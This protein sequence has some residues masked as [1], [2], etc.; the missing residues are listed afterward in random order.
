MTLVYAAWIG[1]LHAYLNSAHE[2]AVTSLARD[3]GFIQVSTSYQTS[4]LAKLVGRGDTTVVDAYLS[5]IL[6]QYVDHI[7][8]A[9]NLGRACDALL[10][11]QSDGGLTDARLFQGKDAILSGSASG[12]VSMTKIAQIAG[13]DWF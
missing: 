1:F 2:D 9:L 13:Y 7:A 3:I 10:F 12:I 4:R 5:P 11:M 8:D 6:R